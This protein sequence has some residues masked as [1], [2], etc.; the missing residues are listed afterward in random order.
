[1]D[2]AIQGQMTPM[3]KFQ[4]Q[5]VET[6]GSTTEMSF[7]KPVL[8]F[9]VHRSVLS[10]HSPIFKDMFTLCDPSGDDVVEGCRG[11]IIRYHRRFA[12]C[13]SY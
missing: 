4:F 8:E 3:L 11:S 9:R 7:C 12:S 1:M 6:H 10:A 2:K 5:N 13:S